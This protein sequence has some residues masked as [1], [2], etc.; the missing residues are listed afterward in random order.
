MNYATKQPLF[1]IQDQQRTFIIH[2]I[3]SNPNEPRLRNAVYD[4]IGIL[5]TNEDI[6][7]TPKYEVLLYL[8]AQDL[9]KVNYEDRIKYFNSFINNKKKDTFQKIVFLGYP[10]AGKTSTQKLLF[11]K[12]QSVKILNETNIPTIGVEISHLNFLDLKISLF[13]TSGQELDLWLTDESDVFQNAELIIFFFSVDDWFANKIDVM[14][15]LRKFFQILQRMDRKDSDV[16]IFCHKIDILSDKELKILKNEINPFIKSMDQSIYYTSLKDGGNPDLSAG[17]QKILEKYSDIY[18]MI[19]YL[20]RNSLDNFR[21]KPLCLIDD[22]LYMRVM[23][24]E[25]DD[26]LNSIIN[27]IQNYVFDINLSQFRNFGT[28]L[29][30]HIFKISENTPIFALLSFSKIPFLIGKKLLI[31]SDHYEDIVGF[32]HNFR[33]DFKSYEKRVNK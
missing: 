12:I 1:L 29:E 16:L 27:S 21:I 8:L 6:I 19:N 22:N 28:E 23:K 25:I 3:S 33:S 2:G 32:I 10:N 31:Y 18:K 4:F 11:Q 17:I 15:K 9:M 14:D 20:F 30:F 26:K 13:D 5:L 7:S 24:S